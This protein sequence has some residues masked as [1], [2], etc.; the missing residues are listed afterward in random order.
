MKKVRNISF[1][2]CCVHSLFAQQ[3]DTVHLQEVAVT[4]YRTR[5]AEQHFTQIKVDSATQSNFSN[6]S[7]AQMLLQNNAGFIK[8]YGPANIASLTLRGS[9]AQQT[10]VVWNGMNINNPM[11]GQADVSLLP[12]GFF[13]SVSLQKGALSGY[14]GSGAMA[15]VLN[16]QS[17]ASD[18]GTSVKVASAYS[19]WKNFSQLVSLNG[20]AGK[21]QTSVK[22]MGEWAQNQYLYYSNPDSQITKRQTHAQNA[23]QALL[24]DACYRINKKQQLGLHAWWQEAQR[25]MPYTLQEKKQDAEQQ[26]K[27]VR[28][29]LDWKVTA[30]RYAFT[31]RAAFFNEG[32]IYRN[33][34]YALRTDN[35]FKTMLLDAEAQFYLPNG[36]TVVAGSSNAFSV[37]TTQGYAKQQQYLRLAAFENLE[38][39]KGIFVSSVYG[40]EELFNATTFVPTGGMTASVKPLKWLSAK[41]NGGTIYRYPTLNDLYWN[42]G[43]NPNLK[44]ESGYS[45]DGSLQLQFKYEK[46][47]LATSGTLFS[48][49]VNNW[50]VW[51]PGQN[52]IWSPQN[53]L[54]VWSRGGE[55][56]SEIAYKGKRIRASLSLVTNYILSTRS[57]TVLANDESA[58]RQLPYV[59]MYSG[60]VVGSL[61]YRN[62]ALRAV[63]TYTGYRYLTSDNYGYLTPYQLI[64][65][66]LAHSF[67][68]KNTQWNIF[69]EVNN[70]LNENYYSMA[71]YAMPLRNYRVGLIFNYQQKNKKQ[72]I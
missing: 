68:L 12:V 28:L 32:L 51:M 10:A 3:A 70:L 71:Q 9:T 64:D 48:R 26:D 24:A 56:N 63:Y 44:P 36:F 69:L 27:I 31:S 13:N 39:K 25:Q 33:R 11:L 57:K 42:P 53:V 46:I 35:S 15:G 23:Q 45:V 14:W 60:S 72:S 4:D 52:G 59:P 30:S 21:W 66:R 6:N 62:T 37:G 17:N 55:T 18:G 8:S 29:L 43:G 61:E 19:S 41:I 49:K 58:N 20:G 34:T 22:W 2:L 50:I 38:W 7:V 1:L 40:R 16:L 65:L 54:E 5:R 67:I 47:S